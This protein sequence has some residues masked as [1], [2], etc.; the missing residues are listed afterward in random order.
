[1]TLWA[2]LYGLQRAPEQERLA[3]RDQEV[4]EDAPRLHKVRGRTVGGATSTGLCEQPS[5]KEIESRQS[6]RNIGGLKRY[7]INSHTW[8]TL[9]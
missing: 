9:G 5:R 4:E 6:L 1:M 3:I 2:S 8:D 7:P